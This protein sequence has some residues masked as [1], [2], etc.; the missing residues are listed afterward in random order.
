MTRWMTRIEAV[1]RD[2]LICLFH[3]F[4]HLNFVD[5][6]CGMYHCHSLAIAE[7]VFGC[8]ELEAIHF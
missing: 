5:V 1:A 3:F 7:V 6:P 4:Q 8:E 2:M